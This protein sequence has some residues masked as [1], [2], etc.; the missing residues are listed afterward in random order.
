MHFKLP[1]I[2]SLNTILSKKDDIKAAY[3][4]SETISKRKRFRSSKYQDVD[5]ELYKYFIVMRDKN[6]EIRTIDFKTKS[7]EIAKGYHNFTVSNGYL[8]GFYDRFNIKCDGLHAD[9]GSV[10]EQ[11]CIDWFVKVRNLIKDYED[12]N[13]YN[14][15]ETG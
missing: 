14:L 13:V 12:K 7:L 9:V 3:E 8:R 10:D 6:A 4:A 2:S 11:T 5:E 15:D 1:Q